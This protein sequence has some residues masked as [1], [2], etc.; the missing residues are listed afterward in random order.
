MAG[1]H[2]G[3]RFAQSCLWQPSRVLRE[4][5]SRQL[6]NVCSQPPAKNWLIS[7]S[8]LPL[9][10]ITVRAAGCENPLFSSLLVF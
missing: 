6:N 7:L 2:N 9:G 1:M 5:N 4:R 10:E 8:S 3:V